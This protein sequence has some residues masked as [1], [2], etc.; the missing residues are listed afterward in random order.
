MRS[1]PR[2]CPRARLPLLAAAHHRPSPAEP[3]ATRPGSPR[4]GSRKRTP[5]LRAALLLAAAALAPSGCVDLNVTNLNQPD[6]KRALSSPEDVGALIEGSYHSWFEGVARGEGSWKGTPGLFLSN[7]A[8]QH[9]PPWI[10]Y[11]MEEY[12]RIPRVAIRTDPGNVF[13]LAPAFAWQNSYRALSSLTTGLRILASPEFAGR[14]EEDEL[15]R[16]QA[17]ARFVQG[18]AHGTVALLHDRGF[19]LDEATDLALPQAPLGYD[20]LME[21]ALAY[22]D[23]AVALAG[24]R[25]FTIPFE[26]MRA[27]LDSQGLIRLARSYGARFRAQV[28]RTPEERA[29]VDWAAVIADVDAGIRSTHSH[30]VPWFTPWE[31]YLL[32]LFVHSG[33]SQL[34]YFMY[35]MADQSGAVAEWYAL[36]MAQK[37][38]RLPDGR[39]VLIVTPDLRFPRGATVEQQRAQAGRYFR[40]TAKQEEG[41]T[42]KRPDRGTW[43]WSWYKA[44]PGVG[45]EYSLS[46]A[47][48]VQP[49]TK[50]AE[51]RLLKAEGL[52][53][54]GDRA[55]AAA[56]VNETRV[57]AGLNATDAAGTNTS[58]V[59]RLP[60]GSCGDLWEMLKWEK[61]M[62][63]AFSGLVGVA[64][65]FD[66]R[67]W[68]DLWKD[69]PLQLPIPCAELQIL[70]M[71][72]CNTFGGPGGLLG[73]PGSTYNF[74][75]E[76]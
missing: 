33:W 20:A 5:V 47:Y 1:R 45:E 4:S 50:L 2:L 13:Y 34:P 53:R 23:E 56:I 42:W 25:S 61:R 16:Y 6:A 54:R 69:T 58:C 24:A 30:D 48:P 37:S 12:S 51:M 64:W 10:N 18:L 22:L 8:F 15:V 29:A 55:G 44:G 72:P 14:I 67:G 26:W 21:R 40:I 36:P 74:P 32:E 75:F 3:P 9:A 57:A 52:Y 59:P 11:G 73:S 27:E 35:G 43:R 68:G 70:G 71:L 39:P 66:G 31:H 62:E 19:V 76:R 28:A 17:F 63:T 38:Y 60:N 7:Q 46:D 49:E 65:F 41:N